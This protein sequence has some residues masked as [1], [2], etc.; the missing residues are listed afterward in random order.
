MEGNSWDDGTDEALKEYYAR[1]KEKRKKYDEKKGG[2]KSVLGEDK[3]ADKDGQDMH[4]GNTLDHTKL[5]TLTSAGEDK[6]TSSNLEEIPS[7]PLHTSRSGLQTIENNSD[8]EDIL[9]DFNYYSSAEA[10]P[11]PPGQGSHDEDVTMEG[12]ASPSEVTEQATAFDEATSGD[13]IQP[14]EG[15][16]LL[17]PSQEDTLPAPQ[18][19]NNSLALLQENTSILTV[20]V[21]NDIVKGGRS[22]SPIREHT[23]DLE[24]FNIKEQRYHQNIQKF[25]NEDG[26]Y[27]VSHPV[28]MSLFLALETEQRNKN[29]IYAQNEYQM[30]H[31]RNIMESANF[32]VQIRDEVSANITK[33]IIDKLSSPVAD[34]Q[35]QIERY[36]ETVLRRLKEHEAKLDHQKN[37]RLE[38]GFLS[39]TREEHAA[40]VL[41]HRITVLKEDNE[42]LRSER[43]ELTK[44]NEGARSLVIKLK[45][46]KISWQEKY[47]ELLKS[48]RP[49]DEEPDSSN[50]KRRSDAKSPTTSL[51]TTSNILEERS[52]HTLPASSSSSRNKL[53]SDTSSTS[54]ASSHRNTSSST[55]AH[56]D[57]GRS[58]STII[59]HEHLSR[60]VE[61]NE[62]GKRAVRA[63]LG[64]NFD[65]WDPDLTRWQ[66]RLVTLGL[67][68]REVRKAQRYVPDY[69]DDKAAGHRISHDGN[70]R[71]GV[72]ATKDFVRISN[73]WSYEEGVNDLHDEYHKYHLRN[74][75]PR[76]VG[77]YKKILNSPKMA[78]YTRCIPVDSYYGEILKDTPGFKHQALPRFRARSK[79]PSRRTERATQ[80]TLSSTSRNNSSSSELNTLYTWANETIGECKVRRYRMDLLS[81]DEISEVERLAELT[82]SI[83]AGNPP[84]YY[85]AMRDAEVRGAGLYF[86]TAVKNRLSNRKPYQGLTHTWAGGIH[87]T[88]FSAETLGFEYDAHQIN[89]ISARI[90]RITATAVEEDNGN[91]SDGPGGQGTP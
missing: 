39:S 82:Q 33:H 1:Q 22:T 60:V 15:T 49:R 31:M 29:Y 91:I 24:F 30:T 65:P 21:V 74:Y 83:R 18:Q 51:D 26:S 35:K 47:L 8:E 70:I 6:H 61:M 43:D 40:E 44:A 14:P 5:F 32:A 85:A 16:T 34:S 72:R 69:S 3:N 13:Q 78:A 9:Q 53:G 25:R 54:R 17:A 37:H 66:Q 41:T 90:Y 71:V 23:S 73:S 57:R 80:N 28:A 63:D 77:E 55:S 88:D 42:E 89:L 75:I 45:E 46:E 50:A 27:T 52:S 81:L 68:K 67:W 4:E 84:G 2:K 19:E 11:G 64:L 56:S 36:T 59:D 58:S 20:D 62:H 12:V 48:K 10:S 87:F 79:S 38:R 76:V 7:S 86:S